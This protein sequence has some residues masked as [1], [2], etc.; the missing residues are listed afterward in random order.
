M[1]DMNKILTNVQ[2]NLSDPAKALARNNI[3][4]FASSNAAPEYDPE[5]TYPIIGTLRMH[6][7]VLYRNKVA[8]T[9]K[10]AWTE[11][12]WEVADI[13]DILALKA[14]KSDNAWIE[15]RSPFTIKNSF[16]Q[17]ISKAYVNKFLGL[18]Q[19]VLKGYSQTTA[20]GT[21]SWTQMF[22]YDQSILNIGDSLS[23]QFATGLDNNGGSNGSIALAGFLKDEN[24]F[25]FKSVYNMAYGFYTSQLFNILD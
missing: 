24:V 2:Q 23:G 18:V 22:D 14:N 8:I 3:G 9:T 7:G 20:A 16:E 15:V 5:A 1:A 13:A 11:A 21:S 17:Q 10:E 19:I 4:A 25:A 12:H 6:D